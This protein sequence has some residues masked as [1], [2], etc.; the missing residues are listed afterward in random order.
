[1]PGRKIPLIQGEYYHVYNRGVNRQKI[2]SGRESYERA[3]KAIF[4]YQNVNLPMKLSD[5]NKL[6]P[7]EQQVLFDKTRSEKKFHVEILSFVLMPNHFHFQLK[8]LS[9]HGISIFMSNFENSY[10]RYLN[11]AI[12]RVGPLYQGRF[13]TQHIKT[14][15]QFIHTSAYIHLNPYSSGVLS[16]T[17]ELLQYKY[18]SLSF[19]SGKE[20]DDLI[21]T[22]KILSYFS[23]RDSYMK[24]VLDRA[25]YQKRLKSNSKLKS[26]SRGGI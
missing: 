24:F 25:D 3:Y 15:E 17:E 22:E 14:R 6:P 13:K 2:F 4:F 11:T 8:Q 18:S 7:C 21:A 26:H 20:K 9:D 19:Y 1:M 23:N 10:A 5:F 16:S 12:E